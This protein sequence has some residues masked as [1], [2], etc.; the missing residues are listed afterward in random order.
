[1]RA[2]M[3]AAL[4]AE[5]F[6][7]PVKAALASRVP[8]ELGDLAIQYPAPWEHCHEVLVR[9]KA[10]GFIRVVN[11]PCSRSSGRRRWAL[12]FSTLA[13]ALSRDYGHFDPLGWGGTGPTR[14]G[15]GEGD[16][17]ATG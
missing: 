16:C 4:P 3:G 10:K 9:T 14:K 11:S 15:V 1:M 17:K 13:F 2:G 7:M 6:G 12:R 5:A 8:I